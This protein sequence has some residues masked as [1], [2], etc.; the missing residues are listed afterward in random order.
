MFNAMDVKDGC[1]L[2]FSMELDERRYELG[3]MPH[4][5]VPYLTWEVG[6]QKPTEQYMRSRFYTLDAALGDMQER[7][8]KAVQERIAG[9]AESEKKGA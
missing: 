1:K 3:Y 4:A 2:L 6:S 7:I 5:E 9:F 8:T